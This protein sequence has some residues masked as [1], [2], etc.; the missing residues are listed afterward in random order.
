MKKFLLFIWLI[1]YT[2]VSTGF[3]VSTHF[4]MNR[5]A[6]VELGTAEKETCDKC[7]MHKEESNGCCRDEVTVV[8]LHQDTETAKTVLPSF[9]LV[10]PV[11]SLTQHLVSPFYNFTEAPVCTAF[12]PPPLSEALYL[13][14]CVFRI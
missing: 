2:C 7:G 4:C 13:S 10:L 12:Q 1:V 9:T 5:K 3:A 8:K 14:N 6:S 11:V